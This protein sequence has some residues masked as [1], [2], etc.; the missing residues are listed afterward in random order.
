MTGHFAGSVCVRPFL[1]QITQ[2]GTKPIALALLRF[3]VA[4]AIGNVAGG[5]MA[6]TSI[7]LHS[8]SPPR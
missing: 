8:P 3:G 7:R 2:L 6:D 1:E 4:S 5:R